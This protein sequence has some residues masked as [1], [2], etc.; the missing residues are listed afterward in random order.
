MRDVGLVF[1]LEKKVAPMRLRHLQGIQRYDERLQ[2]KKLE[3]SQTDPR[4]VTFAG[5]GLFS[6]E[7][8]CVVA[9]LAA[10]S[11]DQLSTLDAEATTYGFSKI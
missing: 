8:S 7:N 10:A 6:G 11:P 2:K 5:V 1:I 9:P 4:F 3:K